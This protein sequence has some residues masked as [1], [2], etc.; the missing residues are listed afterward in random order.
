MLPRWFRAV[1]AV[2]LVALV[3]LVVV[4]VRLTQSGLHAAGDTIS[5]GRSHVT[6]P[7]SPP[8][9]GQ[10]LLLPA[11]PPAGAPPVLAQVGG[12]LLQRLDADTAL[13]ARGELSLVGELEAM[14][15]SRIESV[16]AQIGG[17]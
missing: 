1:V 3:A 14:L 5:W 16:L 4:G 12:P 17:R 9:S 2:E 10:L 13:T 15:R 6:A 8:P 7:A 11:P